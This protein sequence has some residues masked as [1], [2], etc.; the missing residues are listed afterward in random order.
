[1]PY[2]NLGKV[3]VCGDNSVKDAMTLNL[4]TNN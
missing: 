1:M 2:N 3:K 4:E